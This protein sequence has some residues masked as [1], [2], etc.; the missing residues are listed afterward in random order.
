MR[1]VLR[2]NSLERIDAYLTR[3]TGGT[4]QLIDYEHAVRTFADRAKDIE[5]VHLASEDCYIPVTKSI[6][7]TQAQARECVAVM[8]RLIRNQKGGIALCHEP[9]H[10]LILKFTAP[11]SDPYDGDYSIDFSICFSCRNFEVNTPGCEF[12]G[13]LGEVQADVRRLFVALGAPVAE[14]QGE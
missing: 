8:S 3:V 11:E 2:R 13:P 10:Y 1:D 14:M 5:Y 9:H 12:G 4:L 7:L 6:A